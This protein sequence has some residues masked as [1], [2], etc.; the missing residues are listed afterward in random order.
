[1]ALNLSGYAVDFKAVQE[2]VTRLSPFIHRTPIVTS[3]TADERVGR[4]LFFKAE[5]LQQTGAFKIRGALNAVET[6]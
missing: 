1:M 2:A 6:L 4:R 3:G 5:N